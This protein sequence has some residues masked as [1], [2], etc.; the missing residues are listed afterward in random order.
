MSHIA[1][2]PSQASYAFMRQIVRHI[3]R[4]QV[5]EYQHLPEPSHETKHLEVHTNSVGAATVQKN[6]KKKKQKKL[7]K[8]VKTKR[9]HRLPR[10][11]R[12]G[13]RYRNSR[14]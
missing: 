3:R 14:W 6:Q 8:R 1:R 5:N 11:M 13:K 2:G 4:L 10:K 7:T 12:P 9:S